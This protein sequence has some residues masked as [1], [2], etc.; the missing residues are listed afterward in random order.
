MN[1]K[2]CAG[3]KTGA[4]SARGAVRYALGYSLGSHEHDL[5]ATPEERKEAFHAL[6]AAASE[7]DD[8]GVGVVFS[9]AQGRGVRP[10]SVYAKNVAALATADIEMDA[11]AAIATS[12]NVRESAI[13]FVFSVNP[14]ES[15][16]T[17]D[18][19]I[20][21]AAEMAIANVGLG[22]HAQVYSVHRDTPHAHVHVVAAAVNVHDLKVWER[23]RCRS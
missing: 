14:E 7:R 22:S 5:A 19:Q 16:T 12:R 18:E 17:S 21:R 6:L 23:N 2:I 3:P 10:S 4:G 11:L 13:H 1:A 15:K 20:I 8:F 9:P